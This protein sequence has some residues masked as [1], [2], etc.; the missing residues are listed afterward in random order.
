RRAGAHGEA[1]LGG[2]RFNG[3]VARTR[4]RLFSWS[5]TAENEVKLQWSRR[6]NATETATRRGGRDPARSCNGAVARTRRRPSTPPGRS[7]PGRRLQWSRRA[8]A[9]ET[10]P[11]GTRLGRLA[12]CFNGAV[13]QIG[14]AHV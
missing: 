12:G 2:R 14:R 13:A 7:T 4:R 10:C 1:R 6:A 11:P 3:A 9:T 5:L 8:N